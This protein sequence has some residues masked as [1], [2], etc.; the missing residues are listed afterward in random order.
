ML[1]SPGYIFEGSEAL[2]GLSGDAYLYPT[3]D[4]P[5]RKTL[6]ATLAASLML[7]AMAGVAITCP[8]DEGVAAAQSGDYAKALQLFRP[9]ADHGDAGGQY[10]L[11]VMYQYG[12]GVPQD[13][14]EAI[15][16]FRKAATRLRGRAVQPRVAYAK[17]YGVPQDYAEA[18]RWSRKAAA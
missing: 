3:Y 15:E 16:W 14:A 8:L 11:G 13:Y 5:L 4:V 9:L 18:L 2:W 1:L 17:G 10:N 7:V 12:W 6:R